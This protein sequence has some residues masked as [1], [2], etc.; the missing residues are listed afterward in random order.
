M[1]GKNIKG[2]S[3]RQMMALSGGTGLAA[4]LGV[5]TGWAQSTAPA[6][7]IVR[8]ANIITQDPT[9]P[10]A[11]A[12]AVRDGLVLAVGS[13]ADV[14]AH[15]GPDTQ[16]IDAGGR[17]MIPGLN[18]SH[19]HATRAGRFYAAELR[20]DG[21]KSLA[22]GLQ[23]IREAAAKTP[24]GEW[25][26][27]VGSWSPYQFEERRLPTPAELTEAAPDTPVYV[28]FLYSQG[29][30]NRKAVE[31]RG[32][33]A[34]TQAP[35]GT[36]YEITEDGGCIL[37]ATPNP[38]LLY[39]SI[40]AL[41][42][43]TEEQQVLSTRHYY[44]ELNRFGLTSVIDAGG[45]GHTF[46]EDYSGSAALAADDALTVRI[47][48]YLFPQNKGAE[49]AEFER[50]T[51]DWQVGLNL[52][53]KLMHAYV[54][55]GG[56]EFLVWSAGDYENFMADRPDITTRDQWRPQLLNVTRHL[57]K[58]GWPLRIH[59]TYDQSIN[60]ILNVF[61]EAHAL[62]VAEGRLGFAGIRWAIDHGE[63]VQMPTLRRIKAL[64][65]G[66]AMQARMAY[67]GEFFM[68]RYGEEMTRNAPPLR[69]VIDAGIP[70]G[71]GTDATRVAGF[72][73]WL[74]LYWATT[75]KSLG[76]TQLH[77][78]RHQLTREEALFHY[79][80]GSAWFSQEELLKGRLK[81]GQFADF[82]L[83]NAPFLDV[84]DE[85]IKDIQADMTVMNGS[86][87]HGAAEYA[88]MVPDLEP[89]QPEWS[90]VRSFGGYQG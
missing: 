2:L 11:T 30:L 26:R 13:E 52:A 27:V 73:P 4:S 1:L 90:P 17:T 24:E 78:P 80:V 65:G 15:A 8:G 53:D 57:L 32:I 58:N 39:A 69:D 38:D 51:Q 66:M 84:S 68:D 34:D 74:A 3:R 86:V 16:D 40:G 83:L 21:V 7:M 81:P 87:V 89:I 46:P 18:D 12:L 47:S 23:M 71:L 14:A 64:G 43:L 22:R 49:L 72:N 55:R 63:T 10:R 29:F 31:V 79:T 61:E 77:G 6:D 20:W 88:G 50:W 35:P 67:A 56:G 70:L 19:H 28:L 45:G 76:G 36:R 42:A 41:P 85:D 33:T 59:A 48:N 75:G 25:V 54:I 44:R 82:A 37:H 5:G 9:M 60:R 62:E